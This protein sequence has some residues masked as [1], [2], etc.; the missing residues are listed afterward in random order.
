M[1]IERGVTGSPGEGGING[2]FG[3]LALVHA[4]FARLSFVVL[5]QDLRGYIRLTGI[6]LESPFT[7]QIVLD[8][9]VDLMKV[10]SYEIGCSTKDRVERDRRRCSGHVV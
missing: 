10:G 6:K 4:L 7:L 9:Q 8:V 1:G 3:R 5:V 2:I